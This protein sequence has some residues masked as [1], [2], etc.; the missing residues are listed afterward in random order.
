MHTEEKKIEFE[1]N[2]N[3]DLMR[4]YTKY[5]PSNNFENTIDQANK[6]IFAKLKKNKKA[7]LFSSE[8]SPNLNENQF[9]KGVNNKPVLHQKLLSK[10]CDVTEDW[11]IA[12]KTQHLKKEKEKKTNKKIFNLLSDW[13]FHSFKKEPQKKSSK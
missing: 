2:Q 12:L 9:R 5:F 1:M 13:F 8:K 6:K 7:H 4:F 10:L 11:K 3:F